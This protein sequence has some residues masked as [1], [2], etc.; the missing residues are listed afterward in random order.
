MNHLK[1]SITDRMCEDLLNL[2]FTKIQKE[3]ETIM[4]TSSLDIMCACETEEFYYKSNDEPVPEGEPIGLD[5]E[6]PK[7]VE[8]VLFSNIYWKPDLCDF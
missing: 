7:G 4:K 3:K 5:I 1:K 8:L 6:T 2:H